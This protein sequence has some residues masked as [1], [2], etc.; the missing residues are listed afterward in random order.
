M[1]GLTDAAVERHC[2]QLDWLRS[3]VI[4]Y[5]EAGIL[6]GA[7]ELQLA[8]GHV[9]FVCE[10]ALT[11]ETAWQDRGVATE[12]MR[13]TLIVARNRSARCVRVICLGDNHR[14]QHVAH[15][16]GAHFQ[17]SGGESVGEIVT[18][19]PTHASFYEEAIDDGFGWFAAAMDPLKALLQPAG[20]DWTGLS[21]RNSV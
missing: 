17:T 19:P 14:I 18:A 10:V 5:F 12:L 1:G 13:R 4:G 20:E 3:V 9:P 15:K 2:K 21:S 7:A 16:F 8:D 6:R 11:V